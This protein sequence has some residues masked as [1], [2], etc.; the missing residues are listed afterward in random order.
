MQQIS[1]QRFFTY[2][3]TLP[4]GKT[5]EVSVRAASE[6]VANRRAFKKVPTAEK[7]ELKG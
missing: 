2:I 6:E 1:Q 5:K 3:A 4:S 7:M